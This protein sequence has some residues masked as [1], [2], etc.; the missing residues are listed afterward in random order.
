MLA[1]FSSATTV[2]VPLPLPRPYR[3]SSVQFQCI[4]PS[5]SIY[6]FTSRFGISVIAKYDAR[7]RLGW[8]EYWVLSSFSDHL[9]N[10]QFCLKTSLVVA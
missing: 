6:A 8:A 10:G 7:V 3:L 2:P 9:L 5:G 4:P 1:E